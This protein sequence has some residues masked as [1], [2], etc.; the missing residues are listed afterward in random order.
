MTPHTMSRMNVSCVAKRVKY[1]M[2]C[3]QRQKG[4]KECPNIHP[5]TSHNLFM[6]ALPACI[7]LTSLSKLN[8]SSNQSTQFKQG[9]GKY[10]GVSSG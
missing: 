5:T 2:I 1:F 7:R 6:L 9:H 3:V 10:V 8:E 4:A